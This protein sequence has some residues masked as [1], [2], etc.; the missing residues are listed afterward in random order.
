MKQARD[1]AS[2]AAHVDAARSTEAMAAAAA[3]QKAAANAAR[4]RAD[5]SAAFASS[6]SSS[7][8]SLSRLPPP[9]AAAAA[10]PP[11]PPAAAAA[12]ADA[13]PPSV[14]LRLRGPSFNKRFRVFTSMNFGLIIDKLC[15]MLKCNDVAL[16]CQGVKLTRDQTPDDVPSTKDHD[17]QLEIM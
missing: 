13:P 15:D 17:V 6:Y 12:T 8:S 1:P 7:S 11:T 9:A 5:G 2:A 16:T 4:A 10:A 3:R 14:Q